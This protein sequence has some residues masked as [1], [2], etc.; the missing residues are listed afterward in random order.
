[1]FPVAA[2][3]VMEE[4][5]VVEEEVE[6]EEEEEEEEEGTGC[7]AAALVHGKCRRIR[8]SKMHKNITE[9][10]QCSENIPLKKDTCTRQR[11]AN[12]TLSRCRCCVE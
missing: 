5:E 3:V 11:I 6:E 8:F 2:A 1:L 7:A 12:D 4:E 10:L 9:K